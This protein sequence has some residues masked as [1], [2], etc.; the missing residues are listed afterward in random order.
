[1]KFFGRIILAF[2]SNV[3]GILVASHFIDGFVISQDFQNI[4]MVAGTLM[5]INFFVKPIF[6]TLL[7]PLIWLSFGLVSILINAGMLYLLDIFSDNVTITTT[8]SLIYATLLI[9]LINFLIGFSAKSLYR[10]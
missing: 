8:E 1:M 5:L 2:V 4:L 10:E 7:T 9:S 6:S 3:V